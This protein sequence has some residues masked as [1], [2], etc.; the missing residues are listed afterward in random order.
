MCNDEPSCFC[1]MGGGVQ[2]LCKA[3]LAA[4]KSNES[5]FQYVCKYQSDLEQRVVFA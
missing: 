4:V 1:S 2:C 5:V 3:G